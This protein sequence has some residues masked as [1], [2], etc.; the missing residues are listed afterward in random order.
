MLSGDGPFTVFAPTNAAFAKLPAGFVDNLLKP[1]NKA[2][3][4]ALLKYH[5]VSGKVLSTDLTNG[6]VPTLEGATVSVDLTDGVKIN[7]ANVIDADNTAV[8]GV[9]HIVDTVASVICP[10]PR[11]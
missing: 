5:V 3:L 7:D 9:V 8:N 10:T 4:I 1:E 6:D 11:A 2:E